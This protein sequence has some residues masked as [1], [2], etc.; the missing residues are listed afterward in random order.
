MHFDQCRGLPIKSQHTFYFI[1]YLVI[2]KSR[3][4]ALDLLSGVNE[5]CS[6]PQGHAIVTYN[7]LVSRP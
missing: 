6:L 5:K 3:N 7:P 1:S 4:L 2:N